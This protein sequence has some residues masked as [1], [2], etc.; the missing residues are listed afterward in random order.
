MEQKVYDSWK[1]ALAGTEYAEEL[2][3]LCGEAL[4]EAFLGYLEFGTAGM[5]GKLGLGINR[6]NTFT[7]RRSTQGLA[8]FIKA[9]GLSDKGVAI[10]YDSRNMSKEF[11]KETAWLLAENGIK[12]YLYEDLRSVPQLSFTILQLGCAA[13]VVIT[14]S[15]NPKEYNGY[16]VY[17]ADGGQVAPDDAK[18]IT[19]Y[20]EAVEDY[21]SIKVS[22]NIEE[23]EN[24]T[25][26]GQDMDEVYYEKLMSI[27]SHKEALAKNAKD[28]RIVYTPLHGSGNKPVREMLRR[29]GIEHVYVVAEQ[30][31]PNGDFPTVIV[32]NPESR[33]SYRLAFELAKEKNANMI[34]ATDPDSDRMGAAVL[35]GKGEW[36]LLTG[37][38]IGCLLMDHVLSGKNKDRGYIV[39]SVVSTLMADEVAARYGVKSIKVLT[40]FRFIA[41]QIKLRTEENFLFGFE[42]SY[43]YL[44]GDFVRDKDGIQAAMLIAEAACVCMEKGMTLYDLAED[45]Y[46]RFGFYSDEV[47]SITR[48][49]LGG[50]DRIKNVVAELREHNPVE[51]GEYAVR[52]VTDIEKGSVRNL[53]SGERSECT[54]PKSNVLMFMTAGGRVILRPS[55]TEPKLKAYLSVRGSTRE[56]SKEKLAALKAGLME[57]IT[58]ILEQ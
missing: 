46:Q 47:I 3:S 48:P 12:V 49:E 38:E 36:H 51:F 56:E 8:N 22:Q 11:A 43:G 1:K 53:L 26:L 24:I 31:E 7:V 30:E 28:L 6:M 33:D 57:I 44:A 15:H 19:E 17:G 45:M 42:E 50:M 2:N 32:P 20:I 54:F 23:Q 35:D 14:A 27:L 4:E 5:R 10:A 16:K 39:N 34:I 18:K 37:N 41:E 13:G 40:G 52:E 9:E 25:I 29:I 21:L 55:G 58:P